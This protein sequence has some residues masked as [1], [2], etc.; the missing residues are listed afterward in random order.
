M[1]TISWRTPTTPLPM[2]TNPR[3][4]FERIFGE[5]G[6]VQERR[7]RLQK[8]RSILDSISKEAGNLQRE[9]G[10][11]DRVRVTDYLDN[12][13]EIERWIEQTER[14]KNPEAVALDAPVGVPDGFD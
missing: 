2:E 9:L 13:R 14:R 12:I 11:R 4:A 3:A 1:N 10:P 8:Q 5:A 7:E 6:T